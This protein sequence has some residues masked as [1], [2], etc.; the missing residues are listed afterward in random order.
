MVVWKA[1]WQIGLA[2]S[3]AIYANFISC[4]YAV[5]AIMRAAGNNSIVKKEFHQ[6]C[7]DFV[8]AANPWVVRYFINCYTTKYLYFSVGDYKEFVVP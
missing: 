5:F 6:I 3:L 1:N 4:V 7:V 2:F 8:T